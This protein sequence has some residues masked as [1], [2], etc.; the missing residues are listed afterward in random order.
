MRGAR[1]LGLAA[2]GAVVLAAC[3]S[4][5]ADSASTTTTTA[6]P[7]LNGRPVEVIEDQRC[8]PAADSLDET[9]YVLIA[10][11]DFVLNDRDGEPFSAGTLC[12]FA[13]VGRPPK[14]R[15]PALRTFRVVDGVLVGEM[16]PFA[17]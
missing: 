16:R 7:T 6:T 3:W 14:D 17:V 15:E 5:G 2:L 8:E 1:R 11:E 13:L 4:E 9:T 12:T 10:A